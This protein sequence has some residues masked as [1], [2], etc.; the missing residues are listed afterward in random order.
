MK[1]ADTS[2]LILKPILYYLV[3]LD[4]ITFKWT[5]DFLSVMLMQQEW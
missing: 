2:G 5:G 3:F 1:Y 4:D